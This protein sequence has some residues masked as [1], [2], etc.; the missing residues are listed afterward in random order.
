[1]KSILRD[2]LTAFQFCTRIPMPAMRAHADSLSDSLSFFPLVGLFLGLAANLLHLFLL[3]IVDA[4]L[5]AALVLLF[6][7]MITGGLHEDGLGDAADG[8]GGG[9]NREQV[10]TIMRDSRVGSYGVI[11]L[12]FSLLLRW[13]LFSKI[14]PTHFLSIMVAAQVL[15]RWS[16]LPLSY[17][18]PAARAADGQGARVAQ[19]TTRKSLLTGSLIAFIIVVAAMHA[20]AWKPVL[21]ACIVSLLTGLYYQKRIGGVTG[22]CFGATNQLVEIAVYFIGIVSL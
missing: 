10:L 3:H 15:C 20:A 22:D 16:T 7:I 14:N 9:W 5:T 1:M 8:F 18:L 12:V 21:L 11:A 2:L 13:L 19:L 4:Q 6:L 17:F